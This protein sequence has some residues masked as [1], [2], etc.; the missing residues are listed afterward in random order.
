MDVRPRV[1]LKHVVRVTFG[2]EALFNVSPREAFDQR[3][4]KL[5]VSESDTNI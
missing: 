4:V 2:A 3:V 5:S 1:A